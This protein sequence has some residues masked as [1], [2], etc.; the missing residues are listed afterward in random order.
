MHPFVHLYIGFWLYTALQCQ[1]SISSNSLVFH[2]SEGISSSPAAFLFLIFF[3]TEASSCVN[4]PCLM[5]NYLL[6]ILKTGSCVTCGGFRCKFSKCHFDRCMRS[7]WLVTI[8]PSPPHTL[9]PLSRTFSLLYGRWSSSG[10][11]GGNAHFFT[12]T[13]IRSGGGAEKID[14]QTNKHEQCLGLTQSRRRVC[15]TT[16]PIA[17]MD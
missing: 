15:N 16:F 2:T 9:H 12:A 6:I 7:C 1:S 8:P 10:S 5:S 11:E 4:G 14:G 13:T 17:Y 3:N